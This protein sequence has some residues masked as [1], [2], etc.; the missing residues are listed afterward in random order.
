[1]TAERAAAIEKET[2]GQAQNPRWREEREWRVTASR[3]G[4][5]CR[6]T[7]GRDLDSLAD[8]IAN[9]P[10]LNRVPSVE[11]GK[12]Y[13]ATA[14]DA[15]T[16]KTNKEILGCGLF[17]DPAYPFLGASPDGVVKGEEAIIEVKCPYV[18]RQAKIEPN[19]KKFPFLEW[20]DKEKK[21]FRLKRTHPYFYQVTGEMKLSK[22]DTCYFVVFTLVDL[23]VEEI[24]LDGEFFNTN[25]LPV[26]QQFYEQHY[27]PLVAAKFIK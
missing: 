19:T 6:A 15:F 10:N 12:M 5:I 25:M 16:A 8:S 9:P 11:H 3:F 1:M 4:E 27:C 2:R 7:E 21:L 18:G 14:I 26:L 20:I 23:Y 13:E 22:R 17:I 24:K